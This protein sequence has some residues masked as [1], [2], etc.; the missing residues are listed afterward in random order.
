[1]INKG[2]YIHD[3]VKNGWALLIADACN[4]DC[5]APNNV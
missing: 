2:F 4:Y 3:C 5:K 1:M